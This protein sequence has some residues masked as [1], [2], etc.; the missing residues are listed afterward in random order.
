MDHPAGLEGLVK[1]FSG[2]SKDPLRVLVDIDGGHHRTGCR[3]EDAVELANSVHKVRVRSL[4]LLSM[5]CIV[6]SNVLKLCGVQ[7]YIGNIRE[8]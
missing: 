5:S 7:S 1:A 6:Q 4:A 2:H 8:R 3:P